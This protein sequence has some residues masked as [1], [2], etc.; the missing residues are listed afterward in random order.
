[1]RQL[2]LLGGYRQDVDSRL[3]ALARELPDENGHSQGFGFGRTLWTYQNLEWM[4]VHQLLETE[5]GFIQLGAISDHKL[6]SEIAE[7]IRKVT[8]ATYPNPFNVAI[9]QDLRRLAFLMDISSLQAKTIAAGYSH[10]SVEYGSLFAADAAK[11]PAM[12]MCWVSLVNTWA[13]GGLVDRFMRNNPPGTPLP[14][15][16]LLGDVRNPKALQRLPKTHYYKR[17]SVAMSDYYMLL[18]INPMWWRLANVDGD[19]PPT[20]YMDKI[21]GPI[22]TRNNPAGPLV[23]GVSIED[24]SVWSMAP[25]AFDPGRKPMASPSPILAQPRPQLGLKPKQK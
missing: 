10:H 21:Y 5:A 3:G 15:D 17:A 20:P 4:A 2:L 14:A 11:A 13:P 18:Q 25:Q 9:Y 16:L 6:K 7:H 24:S 1:M 23:G 8:H 22:S 12:E 19:I